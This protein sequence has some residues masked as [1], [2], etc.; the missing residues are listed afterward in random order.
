MTKQIALV[1]A[2]KEYQPVEY[3]TT[4]KVIEQAGYPILTVSDVAG[5]ATATDGS[6]TI[7]DTILDEVNVHELAGLFFI[8]GSG[9]LEHLDHAQSY[10]LAQ[11]ANDMNLPVGAICISV[12]I[13][14]KADILANRK[15]TGWDGDG[16]L[17]AVFQEHGATRVDKPVV[18][19]QNIVTAIGPDQ[20]QQFGQE[21]VQLIEK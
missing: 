13:L 19:D 21:I 12:R 8:G 1:I 14:A 4:K 7:V 5:T 16:E 20:A 15:A 6:T 2:H 10:K 11:E 3:G 9:A 18:A 17:D